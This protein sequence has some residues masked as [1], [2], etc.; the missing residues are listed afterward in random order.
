MKNDEQV[1]FI[2]CGQQSAEEKEL[3]E[4]IV[5]LVDDLTPY[6][7]YFAEVQTTLEGLTKNIFGGLNRAAGFIVVLHNRGT[8]SPGLINRA[9]VWVEQEIAI[10]AFIQQI[11]GHNLHVAA[12]MQSGITLEGVRSQLLLNP[13]EFD[14]NDKVIEH[15]KKILPSWKVS[16][17]TVNSNPLNITIGYEKVN[18]RAERHDYRLVVLLTNTGYSPISKYHVDLEFPCQMIEEPDKIDSYK[19]EKSTASY[20]FFRATQDKIGELFPGDSHRII[21]IPYYVDDN[22]FWHETLLKSVV[23]ATVHDHEHP[24]RK[25]EKSMRELQIF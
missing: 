9:S 17:V 13:M 15:L 3:G 8:V 6:K 14:T 11:L 16:A 1:V 19:A 5:T 20:A 23:K 18:I 25:V 24:P 7:P 4:K 22:I 2:S 12:Y 21:E 10:A